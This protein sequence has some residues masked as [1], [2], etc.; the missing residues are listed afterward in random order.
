[1]IQLIAP[2][3]QSACPEMLAE[4]HRLRWRVFRGRLNWA[5]DGE[6][7]QERDRF[8]AL[9]PHY[10][11][12]HARGRLAGTVRFLPTLGPTMLTG[13][14][15]ALLDGASLPASASVWESSRFA[16]DLPEDSAR[17][18]GLAAETYALLAGMIEFGL[19]LGLTRIVT[20]T[21]LR[22]E[23]ILRR[24]GWPL[25]R[26][27]RPCAYGSATAIAGYLPVS[28]ADLA[29]IRHRGGLDRPLLW[30]PALAAGS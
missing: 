3:F 20:V 18:G 12:L 26:I 7:E 9:R 29:A 8:D 11:L 28:A 2:E 30:R 13:V 16:L 25:E 5:V 1:M 21:D 17:H 4:M 6:G 14:F 22:M 15:Q 19:T 10:L 27:G 24:A 23:R